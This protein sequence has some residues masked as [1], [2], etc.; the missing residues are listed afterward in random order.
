M[1]IGARVRKFIKQEILRGEDGVVE[2]DDTPLL[3]GA[4]DSVGLLQLVAF[5]EEEFHIEIDDTE[6]V[7]E[8]FSTVS[9]I[10]RLV[11]GRVREK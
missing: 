3:N 1:E 9:D 8:H 4:V 2:S 7:P 6:I 5:L 10:E 11:A